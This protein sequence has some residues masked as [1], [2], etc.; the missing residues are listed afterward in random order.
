MKATH[1]QKGEK[2]D[3][4]NNSGKLIEN[5]TIIAIGSR[6]GIAG[7]DIPGGETGTLIVEGVFEL[8]KGTTA[9]I[10]LGDSVTYDA[11]AGVVATQATDDTNPVAGWAVKEAAT[12][13]STVL[14]KI[15]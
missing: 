10:S 14:V 9:A 5:G 8:P 11:D 1:W 7:M 13:D 2:I 4:T 6:V 15:G 3:Y 12:A